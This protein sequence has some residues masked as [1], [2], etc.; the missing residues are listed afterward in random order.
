[1][2]SRPRGRPIVQ[3]VVKHVEQQNVAS[4]EPVFDPEQPIG[5][6]RAMRTW[7]TTKGNQHTRKSQIDPVAR[8]TVRGSPRDGR[9]QHR[10]VP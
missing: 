3:H 2:S 7:Y 8:R 10:G 5:S 4:I 9:G 6:T 1:M